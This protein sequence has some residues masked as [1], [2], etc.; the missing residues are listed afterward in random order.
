MKGKRRLTPR[1]GTKHCTVR[2]TMMRQPVALSMFFV[3]LAIAS[4]RAF[5]F[6]PTAS[7]RRAL[8]TAY[9]MPVAVDQPT[10]V[11]QQ[12]PAASPTLST[13]ELRPMQDGI[14]QYLTT[15]PSSTSSS[16]LL[17]LQER[18]IPTPEEI[19]AKKRN[20]NLWFWGGG[21]VAPFIATIFY[22]GFRFWEK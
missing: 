17:S 16:E 10:I 18:H 2:R 5:V 1:T 9:L 15:T 22:F 7:S 19:A 12:L 14:H 3:A 4:S 6:H 20:F 8:S 21:F 11:H 13:A